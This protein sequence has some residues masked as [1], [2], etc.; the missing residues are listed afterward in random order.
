MSSM[1]SSWPEA[2]REG[3]LETVQTLQMWSQIV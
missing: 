3:W 1:E 2:P